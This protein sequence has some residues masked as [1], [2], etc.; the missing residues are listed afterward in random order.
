MSITA[1]MVKELRERT[2][3]GMMECKKALQEVN[4]DIE[5][6]ITEMRKKGQAKAAK[7]AGKI[8]AE[9][10]IVI[11]SSDDAKQAV[12]VEINS[13][14]DFVSRGDDFQQFASQLAARAL[15]SGETENDAVLALPAE[16]DGS[17]TLEQIRQ[18]LSARLGENI[19]LRRIKRIEAAYIGTYRHGDRIGVLVALDKA[20]AE[21]AKDLAMHIAAANP[22]SI[23]A[24]RL[25]SALIAREREVFSAQA[26]ESGKPAN[27][28]EKMVEGRIGKFIKEVC[29]LE[30]AFVKQPDQ[31][32]AALLKTQA[33]NVLDFARFEVGEGIEK[34]EVDFAEEVRA[35]AEGN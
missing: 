3:A 19:Q 6:A 34:A 4:G 29:L 30:Q 5:A 14:T 31:T 7:R 9:G 15:E 11:K 26:A 25:D 12:I 2:G 16:A 33:A 23:D 13:E 1:N 20:E 22:Q 24:D 35:Q 32:V 18:E 17:Q 8:A 21:L 10:V 28:V 27:I